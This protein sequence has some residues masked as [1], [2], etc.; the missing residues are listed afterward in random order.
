MD[1]VSGVAS[2]TQIIAYTHSTSKVLIQLYKLARGDP[3]IFQ[4]HVFSVKVLLSIVESLHQRVVPDHIIAV[5]VEIADL[6]Q[7]A[8]NIIIQ[9]QTRG[10]LG[11]RWTCLYRFSDL[12]MVFASLREKREILHLAL[13]ANATDMRGPEDL[14]AHCGTKIRNLKKLRGKISF[15]SRGNHNINDV[16]NGYEDPSGVNIQFSSRGNHVLSVVGSKAVL[17][18]MK[19]SAAKQSKPSDSVDYTPPNLYRYTVQHPDHRRS[20]HSSVPNISSWANSSSETSTPPGTRL[21]STQSE[22][23]SRGPARSQFLIESSP[24][25]AEIE[26]SGFDHENVRCPP[27]RGN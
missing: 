24:E 26:R 25:D 27:E 17:D 4:D 13:T 23:S 21:S 12:S 10:F 3:S 18:D 14:N 2:I 15:R 11:V 20:D 9:S 1:V 5:L 16:G 6:A 8:Q 19:I 22:T 7:A